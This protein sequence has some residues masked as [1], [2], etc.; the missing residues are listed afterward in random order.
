MFLTGSLAEIASQLEAI[1]TPVSIWEQSQ[2]GTF[3]FINGNDLFGQILDCDIIEY[4]NQDLNTTLPR[5]I[6]NQ[7]NESLRFCIQNQKSIENEIVLERHGKVRWWRF[8]YSPL[9]NSNGSVIRVLNTCIEIT[10]KKLLEQSLEKS[11][12]RFEAV[13]NSA[14]DGIISVDNDQNIKMFNQAAAD[15]FGISSAD[16]VGTPLI[17]LLPGRFRHN[18]HNYV[19]GF[20]DSPVMS[21]PMHTRASVMGLRSDGTEFPLEIT[22]SKIRVGQHTEMTAVLRDISERARLI[23]ELRAAAAIDPL[24]GIYNRRHF[25]KQL[26]LERN[27]CQRFEHRLAVVMFDLDNFKVLNDKNGHHYGDIALLSVVNTVKK[28]IREVDVFARWGGDEFIVLLPETELLSAITW[29]KRIRSVV[30][31]TETAE[32]RPNLTLSIGVITSD[33]KD[34]AN[35]ILAKVDQQLYAAKTAGK[36]NVAHLSELA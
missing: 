17:N 31:L 20:N 34:D 36:N 9:V 23:E 6:V 24:T 21:R 32:G 16:A 33:G 29:A 14:Y 15:M 8:L 1:G 7:V 4:L 35:E 13:I 22:I 10:E 27:R 3:V 12:K 2:S 28:N 18:H 11:L 26:D 19:A 30:E 25:V 5:Y